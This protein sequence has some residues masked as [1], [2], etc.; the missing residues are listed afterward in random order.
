MNPATLSAA[1]GLI[2]SLVGGTSTFAAS[3]LT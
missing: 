2:G 1:V 3:W